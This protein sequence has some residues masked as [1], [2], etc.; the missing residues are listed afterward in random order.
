VS[1]EACSAPDSTDRPAVQGWAALVIHPDD[2]VAV[3]LRDVAAGEAVVV[4]RAGALTEVRA[5][6][7]VPLGHKLAL[8]PLAEGAPIRKYGE[9]IGVATRAIAQGAHV[10]VHNLVSVRGRAPS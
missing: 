3:A 10:H 5:V 6:D 1:P 2:D 8:H 7:A 4:R 9:C